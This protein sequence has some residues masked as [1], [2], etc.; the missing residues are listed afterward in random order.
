MAAVAAGTNQQRH[1]WA[2]RRRRYRGP[3]AVGRRIVATATSTVG[4]DPT[5]H[6]SETRVFFVRAFLAS[7]NFLS[8]EQIFP[9]DLVATGAVDKLLSSRV[10]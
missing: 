1:S 9:V 7:V 5:V 4:G 10:D 8:S 3:H 2:G 6:G